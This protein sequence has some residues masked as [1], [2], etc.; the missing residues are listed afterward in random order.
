MRDEPLSLKGSN[1]R[2]LPRPNRTWGAKGLVVL[3]AGERKR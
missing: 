2:A 3:V 1:V